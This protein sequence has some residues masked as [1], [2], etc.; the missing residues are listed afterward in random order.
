MSRDNDRINKGQKCVKDSSWKP[1]RVVSD[2]V[3]FLQSKGIGIFVPKH[4][5][6]MHVGEKI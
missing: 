5:D 3:H 4:F 2:N 1:G 6:W